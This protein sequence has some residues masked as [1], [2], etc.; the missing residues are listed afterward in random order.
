M[1]KTSKLTAMLCLLMAGVTNVVAQNPFDVDNTVTN[2]KTVGQPNQTSINTK[3]TGDNGLVFKYGQLHYKILS[4]KTVEVTGEV[5]SVVSGRVEIPNTVT[6]KNKT[7]MVVG[8]GNNAF[9][10]QKN[11]TQV[12]ISKNIRYINN[13][14][15]AMTGLTDV[16]IPGDNVRVNK[17]AFLSCRSLT[18]VTLSG[19]TPSFD[20]KAF[21]M[22]F[23]LKELRVRDLN[24]QKEG[25]LVTGTPAVMKALR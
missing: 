14:A 17:H 12:V 9:N 15:F 22:C 6:H 7:Y 24:P 5:R 1:K 13:S 3:N 16:V 19:K 4:G 8:I 2:V 11:M 23:K 21:E 25:K 18:K 20:D 10:G